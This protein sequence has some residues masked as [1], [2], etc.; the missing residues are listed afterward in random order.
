[1]SI[2]P[3]SDGAAF[4]LFVKQQQ[5]QNKRVIATYHSVLRGFQSFVAKGS[6][7]GQS[8]SR[9]TIQD[10]LQDRHTVWPAH[11]VVHR[12]WLVGR[13]IDWLVAQGSL[14]SN[15]LTELRQSYG[16]R[17]TAPVVR[18]LL[19]PD[20]TTALEALRMPPRFGS[21]LGPVM[22]QHVEFMRALGF[23]GQTVEGQFLRFDRFLQ[24]RPDLAGLPLPVLVSEW[25][26][27]GKT[28]HHVLECLSVSRAL[29]KALHP[30]QPDATAPPWDK[31]LARAARIQFRAP[32]I[33]TP[34]EVQRLLT[35][36]RSFPAPHT[37]LRPLMLY[38]MVILAYCAGLRLR[39][40]V[41]LTLGDID[42][43]EHTIDIRE[44]KFFKSRRLP[45]TA[46]VMAAIREYLDTRKQS[47]APQQDTDPL[48]WR[49]HKAGG[50]SYSL[51]GHLLVE[52]LRRT[53]LKPASGRVGPRIHDLRHTFVVHRMTAWYREGINPQPRL[54]YLATYLGHKDIH[55]TLVYLTITQ[56][57]L[58]HANARFHAYGAKA[59]DVREG[60][61]QCR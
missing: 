28:P 26:K 50:Y 41:N 10:W 53:G 11:M 55:A 33:Y 20:P 42:A 49:S 14:L 56:E 38:T 58:Q 7:P 2:W 61:S 35:A 51:I 5:F 60:G 45:V 6:P 54:P 23:R 59:L 44:T 9:Q 48:F 37:P 32:Y 22:R 29:T 39:E 12:A 31:Q 46:S 17:A 13:F 1:M 4:R 25:S 18:A 34:E 19:E 15:P 16:Q 57:L 36:A 24:T 43:V 21:P 8:L 3:D 52:L 47:G 27:A 40:I 30:I